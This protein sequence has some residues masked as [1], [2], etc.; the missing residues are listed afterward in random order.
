[1]SVKLS[2]PTELPCHVTALAEGWLMAMGREPVLLIDA[3]TGTIVDANPAAAQLL[4]SRLAKLQGA[5][6]AG[7][8]NPRDVALLEQAGAEARVVGR[9][10]RVTVRRA[11]DA[12]P[13]ELTYSL[14]RSEA[15]AFWLVHLSDP[16]AGMDDARDPSL[17]PSVLESLE[18]AREGFLVT[19]LAFHVE[20]ANAAFL[21]MAELK[22]PAQVLDTL[23]VQ[24]LHFSALQLKT[25]GTQ[26]AE[27][28]AVT[29]LTTALRCNSGLTVPVDVRAVAVPDGDFPCW[30]F[31]ISPRGTQQ[32]EDIYPYPL[33]AISPRH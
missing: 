28:Q 20:Y 2:N 10:G 17:W 33:G 7:L 26:L 30:G 12:V 6:L 4:K 15:T 3:A 27:R 16:A 14:V 32:P 29:L 31:M 22:V 11:A 18:T 19:N 5:S 1:M 9:S 23:A 21:E 13:L 8:I 24:W 25:L